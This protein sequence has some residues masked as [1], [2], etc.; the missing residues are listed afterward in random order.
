MLRQVSLI[1]LC[2]ALA[3]AACGAR[4][5]PSR[6]QPKAEATAPAQVF[7]A[8]FGEADPASTWS[9]PRPS[10]HPVQGF[11]ISV[12][13]GDIDWPTARA[14]GVNFVFMKATEG[15]YL[16]DP[17]FAS[18][19]SGSAA[20]QARWYISHVP[21]FPSAL[22]PVLYM[23]WT[24]RSPTCR[25]KR[26]ATVIRADAHVFLA[27]VQSHYGQRP[28]LYTTTDFYQENELWQLTDADFWLRYTAAHPSERYPGQPW[29]FWQYSSIGTV[30]GITG[31]VDFNT[32]QGSRA[33]WAAWRAG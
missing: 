29:V 11:D 24:P 32:F 12:W 31:K 6:A 4:S 9:G 33:A 28:I 27:A 18:N 1:A 30:P 5:Q 17:A 10:A 7:A 21:R 8:N 2:L 26:P 20:A 23:E 3:L 13:Q 25:A 15:G 19:W 14:N 16:V 22:P